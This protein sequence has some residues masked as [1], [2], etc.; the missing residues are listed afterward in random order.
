M[1]VGAK[2]R[3]PANGMK[4]RS[5]IIALAM[6]CCLG[7]CLQAPNRGAGV[8]IPGLDQF[9]ITDYRDI[10]TDQ[11]GTIYG[12]HTLFHSFDDW[13]ASTLEYGDRQLIVKAKWGDSYNYYQK[14]KGTN[15]TMKK[16][17]TLAFTLTDITVESVLYR[18][19]SAVCEEGETLTVYSPDYYDPAG[20]RIIRMDDCNP[21]LHK[22]D[23]VLL[24]LYGVDAGFP[25]GDAEPRTLL[26][27]VWPKM[28]AFIIDDAT[29]AAVAQGDISQ[30]RDSPRDYGSLY[31]E[32]YP[33]VF[34]KYLK[35]S[36]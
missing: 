13:E 35:G 10:D 21:E 4:K 15:D 32:Y 23:D 25:V 18:G 17:E 16:S 14:R 5:I 33:D 3:T 12:C 36:G 9:T 27:N 22:G 7:G 29:R 1:V 34:S 20:D 6:T 8:S 31:M 30:L 28:G 26:S 19:G 2:G 11:M 24:Y